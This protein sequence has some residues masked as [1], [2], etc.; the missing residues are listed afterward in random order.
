MATYR[1]FA[2]FSI[3]ALLRRYL[4]LSAPHDRI[5]AFSC[6][7]RTVPGDS[8]GVSHVLEHVVLCGSERFP[9]RDPFFKMLSRSLVSRV[10][11]VRNLDFA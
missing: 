4:H 2:I 3:P 9:V 5:N 8:S 11:K 7:L 6:N 10:E 1:H